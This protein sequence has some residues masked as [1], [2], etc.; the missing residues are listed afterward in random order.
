MVNQLNYGTEN[1]PVTTLFNFM[2][3]LMMMMMRRMM[4]KAMEQPI[5][6]KLL[7]LKPAKKD[8]KYKYIP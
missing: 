6:I 3:M 4:I 7:I 5:R 1:T 8:N 2:M